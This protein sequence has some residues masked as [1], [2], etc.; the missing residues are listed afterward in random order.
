MDETIKA[1]EPTYR[2]A[3]DEKDGAIRLYK[4][5]EVD[6]PVNVEV[7]FINKFGHAGHRKS[8]GKDGAVFTPLVD[9]TNGAL[10]AV[11]DYMLLI[12]GDN[13]EGDGGIEWKTSDGR[14]IFLSARTRYPEVDEDE[15]DEEY[16]Y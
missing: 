15:E 12:F 2:L 8:E 14:R 9:I 13:E 7:D 10:Q 5:Q 3:V 4:K 6:G 16:D 11:R 1:K